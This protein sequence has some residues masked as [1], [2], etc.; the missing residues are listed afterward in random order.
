MGLSSGGS[1]TP[2]SYGGAGQVISGRL[3]TAFSSPNQLGSFCAMAFAVSTA[4]MLAARRVMARVASIVIIALVLGALGLSLSRGAWVGTAAAFLYLVVTM[5]EARRIVLAL[6]IPI[7]L[8]GVVLY[9]YAR[10]NAP[11][12]KVI[13]ERTQQLTKLSPYDQRHDIWHEA[14]REIKAHPV[15]GEGP[16]SFP[17]ASL[18]AGSAASTVSAE[19]AHDLW[20]NTAAEEGVPAV[21]LL[22]GFIGSLGVASVSASRMFQSHREPKDRILVQ[23]ITAAL[24]ALLAQE[25]LDHTLTN[26]VVR[27]AA[28]GL[29][30][31]LLAGYGVARARYEPGSK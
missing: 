8:I 31:C 24:I 1:L 7:A 17:V 13:G 28:W 25:L 9:T 12:I 21:F 6:G 2:E 19:H 30:G 4:M 3:A 20:L 16:G 22:L 11:E 15:L 29:I 27:I 23:G 18:R 5:R 26:P 14:E 10:P